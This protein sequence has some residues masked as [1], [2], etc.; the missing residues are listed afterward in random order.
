MIKLFIT[1]LDDTL[2]SWLGF[3]IPAF[4]SMAETVSSIT[5]IDL[6]RL[7]DEYRSIHQEKGTVEYPFA[8]VHLQSVKAC[9]P[10]K[11][12][13]EMKELFR[14]AFDTFNRVRAEN[15]QL[16]PGVYETLRKLRERSISVI[17]FTDSGELNG[18]YRLQQL[19]IDDFF[20]K[21]YVSNY[22]Y[23]LP[24]YV[25][26][27]R[28]ICEA[29]NGKPDPQLLEQI[30]EEA[31]VD[32]S[33]VIYVGDSLTKDICMAHEAGV[34]SIQCKHPVDF[35]A[36]D[37]Y[38]KLVRISSWTNDDFEKDTK[39]R[40]RCKKESIVP[41]YEV[42]N[43]INILD[44]INQWQGE[45]IFTDESSGL[46]PEV[47]Y[48]KSID[49]IDRGLSE[50]AASLEKVKSLQRINLFSSLAIGIALGVFTLNLSKVFI[51]IIL[52]NV[53]VLPL[54][55]KVIRVFKKITEDLEVS[56]AELTS[57]ELNP[58]KYLKYRRDGLAACGKAEIIKKLSD[59][60]STLSPEEREMLS[61]FSD[62]GASRCRISRTQTTE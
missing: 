16:F 9:Y 4:Y 21:I 61:K 44:V 15:L 56:K 45:E 42:S 47:A 40:E 60:T 1:D 49:L 46:T 27:D 38:Q 50:A 11:T 10:G 13:K 59:D 52:Q 17:G 29:K 32:K 7:L 2:Y 8:T 30:I 48:V 6:E 31:G 25:V 53:V 57:G 22:E 62:E 55:V 39:L 24:D 28:R 26:R 23:R 14:P 37:Y 43:Y 41:D 35:D 19:G 36:V 12:D 34:K 33:E 18:F 51:P 58:I 54:S 3:Y 20:D 5:G